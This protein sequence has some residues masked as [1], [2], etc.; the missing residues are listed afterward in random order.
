MKVTLFT[1]YDDST[2]L[3]SFIKCPFIKPPHK[4]NTYTASDKHAQTETNFLKM[5]QKGYRKQF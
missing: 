2:D 1:G 4:R 3:C 5:L